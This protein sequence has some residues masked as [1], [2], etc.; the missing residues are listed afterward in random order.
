MIIKSTLYIA[1][2]FTI[3]QMNPQN[4]LNEEEDARSKVSK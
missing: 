4:P 2:K 3:Y 1:W